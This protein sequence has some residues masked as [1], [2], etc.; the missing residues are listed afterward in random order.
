MRD[1][2]GDELHKVRDQLVQAW[3]GTEACEGSYAVFVVGF[4]EEGLTDLLEVELEFFGEDVLDLGF[5]GDVIVAADGGEVGVCAGAFRD[6]VLVSGV[7]G[8]GVLGYGGLDAFDCEPVRWKYISLMLKKLM[9]PHT[10]QR[11]LAW[12]FG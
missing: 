3:I 7:R 5:Y 8:C 6:E 4:V 1:F 12:N 10:S 9:M 2:F 11:H